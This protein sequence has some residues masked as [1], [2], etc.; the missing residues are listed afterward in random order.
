MDIKI[1]ALQLN[2]SVCTVI[3]WTLRNLITK[4]P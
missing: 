3:M 1:S 4:A 2:C